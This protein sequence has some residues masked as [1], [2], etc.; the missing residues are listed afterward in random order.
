MMK[1][2]KMLLTI[3][4]IVAMAVSLAALGCSRGGKVEKIRIGA[5]APGHLKFVVSRQLGFFDKA[6]EADGIKIEYHAFTEGGSAVITALAN[7]NLDITYTGADPTLRAAAAGADIHLI[8]LSS[9]VSPQ[10]I[11]VAAN[12]SIHTVSDLKGKRVAFLTGTM[13]HARLVRALKNVGLTINDIEPMN[14]PFSASGPALVRGDV[15]AIVESITEFAPLVQAGEGRILDAGKDTSPSNA[16]SV[17]GEFLR[18]HPDIVKKFLQADRD[19]AAWVDANFDAAVDAFSQGTGRNKEAIIKEYAD[20]KFYNDPYPSDDSINAYKDE[21]EF[22]KEAGLADG[23]V[24][25][26]K[27]VKRE[28][29]DEIYKTSK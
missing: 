24:D 28:I 10:V 22:L 20:R 19:L 12:S 13:R 8:A 17:N 7:G 4:L 27:W 26:D 15:D 2:G 3:S 21:A 5:T 6:F 1:K 14:L 11:M 25:F 16:I 18:K 9:P 23:D 29:I